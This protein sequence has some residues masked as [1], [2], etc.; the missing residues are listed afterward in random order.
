MRGVLSRVSQRI[1]ILRL[2]KRIFVESAD[3]LCC[4]FACV[5]PILDYWSP[6]WGSHSAS[7]ATG[8]FGGHG[9][10]LTRVFFVCHR[11]RVA[12]LSIVQ[13]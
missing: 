6:V 5:L 9:F 1:G 10:V 2:V 3:L 13:G 7:R 8:V 11:R 4:Y 12:G